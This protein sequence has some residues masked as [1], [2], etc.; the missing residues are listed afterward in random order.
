M[1]SL[2]IIIIIVVLIGFMFFSQRGQKKKLQQQAEFRDSL[3]PG[4]VVMT[5]S[6]Y[7]GQVV[8][9]SENEVVLEY[10]GTKTV[11]SK[12]AI[13]SEAALDDNTKKLFKLKVETSETSK[14]AIKK[15]T[16]S[17]TKKSTSSNSKLKVS[18]KPTT[19]KTSVKRSVRNSKSNANTKK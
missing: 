3:K 16:N 18:K 13:R 11:W 19:N 5:G 7:I 15:I 17:S 1:D 4:T 14:T 9:Q 2:T 10:D 8:S 6:G 12:Q